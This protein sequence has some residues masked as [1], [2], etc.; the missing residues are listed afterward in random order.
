MERYI[1]EKCSK[2]RPWS[3]DELA[4]I[5]RLLHTPSP[6]TLED[7]RQHRN[8]SV[9]WILWDTRENTILGTA[10]L[11]VVYTLPSLPAFGTIHSVVMKETLK[12]HTGSRLNE[13]MM[14][15]IIRYASKEK[16]E[17]IQRESLPGNR[18]E[19]NLCRRFRFRMVAVSSKSVHGI[20]IYRLYFLPRLPD[21]EKNDSLLADLR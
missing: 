15:C 6:I 12:R 11:S 1:I 9:V 3:S 13:M 20:H 14:R 4:M 7:I 21:T 2:R 8:S 10:S 5:Q 17:H 18:K 19:I 16:L